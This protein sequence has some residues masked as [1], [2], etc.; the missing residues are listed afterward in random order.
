MNENLQ[1][2]DNKHWMVAQKFS[3]YVRAGSSFVV[4]VLSVWSI[5]CPFLF[6]RIL[7]LIS[8]FVIKKLQK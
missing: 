7:F 1:K 8:S 5:E 4:A 6:P 2:K 3:H